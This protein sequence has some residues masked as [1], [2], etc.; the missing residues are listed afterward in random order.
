[1]TLVASSRPPRPTSRSVQSAGVSAMARK[2]AAVVISKKVIG[3]AAV[4]GLAAL[5]LGDQAVL[6]DELAGEA[7]ALVEAGEVGRGVDVDAGAGRLEAGADHRD[8]RSLAVGAGDVDHR[9]Q[10][11]FGMAEDG[12]QA[13]DAAEGEV[14]DL[15]VEAGQAVED[16]VAPGIASAHG[17]GSIASSAVGAGRSPRT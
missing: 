10:A 5:E 16:A 14:D 15:G 7:D 3:S 6:G 4:G 9:R 12:E 11:P 8:G 17:A 13:L 1:M 2:A